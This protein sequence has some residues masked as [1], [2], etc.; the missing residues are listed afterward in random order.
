MF[1][2]HSVFEAIFKLAS[3]GRFIRLKAFLEARTHEEIQMVTKF[4]FGG[5]TPLIMACRNGH[6]EI[7]E[8]LVRQCGAD[9]EETGAVMFDHET[10]EGAPPLWCASAAGHLDIVRF[11]VEAGA[12][13]NSKTRTNSTPL[14]A[15]CFDGHF[16]VVKYLVEHGADFEVSNRH[17]HTCLMIACYKGHYKIVKYLL[18]LKADMNRKSSKGNTA[19][20]DCAE[21]GSIE[22]LKLLLSHGARMDVDSYG[23]TPLLAAAVVGHQHIVEYLIGLNIVSRKEKID[24]LELLGATYVDRKKDMVSAVELWQRAMD[25]RYK[26]GEPHISK[27]HSPHTIDAYEHAREVF[28]PDS[29]ADIVADPDAIKNQALLIR[30]RIL[31]PA[32]PDTIYFLRYRGAMYADAGKFSRCI[33]L[34][35]YALDMQ[36]AMLEP[37]NHMTLS[38]FYSFSELFEYMLSEKSNP[39]TPTLPEQQRRRDLLITADEMITILD[40][41]LLEARSARKYNITDETLLQ[42]LITLSLNISS[43]L[44]THWSDSSS[45]SSSSST[46]TSSNT[47]TSSTQD[48]RLEMSQEEQT[49]LYKTLFELLKLNLRGSDAKS[50]LHLSCHSSYTSPLAP[51]NIAYKSLRPPLIP[52]LDLTRI[53]LRVGADPNDTD[54]QG[55]TA[56]HLLAQNYTQSHLPVIQLLLN[57]GAHYDTLNAHRSSFITLLQVQLNSSLAHSTSDNNN[58]NNNGNNNNGNNYDNQNN[59]NY[60]NG[61]TYNQNNNKVLAP[62]KP[63]ADK[64]F[65][66]YNSNYNDYNN[67]LQNVSGRK[68]KEKKKEKEKEKKIVSNGNCKKLVSFSC[69]LF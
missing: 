20:H 50:L 54:A 29:L 23:M 68:K 47:S 24:S 38:T 48:D 63:G 8:Y 59:N 9:V 26:E 2:N 22:I 66:G 42:R 13:V 53:L 27:P 25:L 32:H 49:R 46:S 67:E 52:N 44:L 18:S 43:L 7:V 58:N 33:S 69:F 45:T 6:R 16:G 30:E 39:A 64:S 62:L 11:L 36:Q 41:C 28:D 55:N 37:L 34:W 4:K 51:H 35:N 14:R 10:V 19:L 5:A 65:I 61:N 31:G 1:L 15:A 57:A 21:A 40:K 60:N 56:L 17:G 3:N 12:Q